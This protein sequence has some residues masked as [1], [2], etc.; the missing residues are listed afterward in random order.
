MSGFASSYIQPVATFASDHPALGA[1]IVVLLA[2]SESLPV[3]GAVFPGTAI[4]LAIAAMAGVGYFSLWGVLAAAVIG[5]VLGD[6]ISYWFGHRYKA[7]ALKIWPISNYPLLIEQSEAFFARHGGKSIAIARFTPVV[8]AFVPLIAGISGMPPVR[9]YTANILSA[10]AWAVSHILPAA[11]AGASLGI[12]HQI[13]ARL[14]LVFLGLLALALLFVKVTQFVLERGLPA[15]A[16]AQQRLHALVSGRIERGHSGLGF[17]FLERLLNPH[18]G[19]VKEVAVYGSLLATGGAALFMIIHEVLVR[20]ELV[21][22]DHAISVMIAGWRTSW[23]DSVMLVATAL[24]DTTVTA[25]VVAVAALWCFWK[26]ERKFALG[27]I[28]ALAATA[29]FVILMKAGMKISRPTLLYQGNDAF[30]FP[31]GHT[32]FAAALYGILGWIWL[33]GLQKPWRSTAIFF[34]ALL[35]ASIAFSRIYLQAHWPSDVAAGLFFGLC[36][37]IV[38]ALSFRA[39]NIEA[40]APRG[41][42]LVVALALGTIGGWHAAFSHAADTALY[43]PRPTPAMTTLAE[44]RATGWHQLPTHRIDLEGDN[45]EPIVLQWAGSSDGL[46]QELRGSGWRLA[47]PVTLETAARFLHGGAPLSELPALPRLHDGRAAVLTLVRASPD[48]QTRQVLYLWPTLLQVTGT[49]PTPIFVAAIVP[50][51]VEHLFPFLSIPDSSEPDPHASIDPA[52]LA[53]PNASLRSDTASQM[54]VVLAGG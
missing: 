53:L 23:S 30:S 10:L 52:F 6:G 43:A 29:A 2:L 26:G 39:A 15:I 34:T 22:A 18:D 42:L 7:T 46:A 45:E 47:A 51:R 31:S 5:A 12:L 20:G 14:A 38:F 37:T 44:W 21:R 3:I 36:L 8:R 33:R 32:S 40:I 17:T 25:S 54:S 27:I 24:G 4:I 48:N 13:S 35:I 49:T 11:A 28:T 16:V 1:L 41:L 19:G 9:F 50:E